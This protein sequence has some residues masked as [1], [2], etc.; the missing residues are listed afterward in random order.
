MGESSLGPSPG[1][2]RPRRND[3]W[4]T[5]K[6]KKDE[7]LFVKIKSAGTSKI[8][9]I[10]LIVMDKWLEQNAEGYKDC[11]RTREGDLVL[12]TKNK[13]QAERLCKQKIIWTGPE[14]TLAIE[15]ELMKSLNTSKGTVYSRELLKIPIEGEEGLIE[16]LA[17]TNVVEIERIKTK[18]KDGNFTESGLHVFTFGSRQP[19]EEIKV[20]YMKYN[21]RTWYPGPMKCIKCMRFGHSK[22][23]CTSP[24][25]IC[26]GCGIERHE[27]HQ[28][29]VKKCI[30]CKP[31]NDNHANFDSRCPEMLFEKAI[32]KMKVDRDISFVAARNEMKKLHGVSYASTLNQATNRTSDQE[33]EEIRK[34]SAE[35]DEMIKALHDEISILA[36]KRKILEDLLIRKKQMEEEIEKMQTEVY[37]KRNSQQ[38]AIS[39]I[40]L[41]P[42]IMTPTNTMQASTYNK[43]MNLATAPKR[44]RK[45]V[46]ILKPAKINANKPVHE[47]RPVNEQDITDFSEKD[48][49]K[50]QE[51]ARKNP[52]AEILFHYGEEGAIFQAEMDF[53]N[54]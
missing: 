29:E 53:S 27:G 10:N 35:T 3:V 40:E 11:R 41:T 42:T 38:A 2:S 14:G 44:H 39:P 43:E 54:Q 17:K 7:G 1:G 49:Q 20:G 34:N 26:R 4:S 24:M 52:L 33:I 51:I 15:I 37:G 21:V 36:G 46:Q 28:C 6:P 22:A 19:P 30:S 23:R 16:Y 5:E 12:L 50:Y 18:D 32:C 8:S 25:E 47:P 9:D 45:E 48:R 13:T 31:P